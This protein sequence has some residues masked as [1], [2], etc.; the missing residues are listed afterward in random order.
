MQYQTDQIDQTTLLHLYKNM[1]KPRL[2]EEK[3]LVLLRQGKI[4]KWFSGIGQEAISVGVTMAMKDE[5][6]IL[7]MHRNLGIFTTRNVPLFRLFCQWQGKMSGFTKGRDRSFHFGTQE[8][9]LI[10]MIS[11]LGPQLGVADG[12]ALASK[13]KN[14]Q[15][16]TAV[17]TGEGGTSEGDF[18]EALNVASVWQLPVLFC[19]ENNGYGLST[20]TLEQY[21]CENLADRGLGY[22]MESHIIDGNNIV[23]VYQK[24]SE[25]TESMRQNPRPI[26]IEFKTFRM[27]GHEEASGTKYVPQ[28][29]M[30]F[31]E[32]KDP[33]NNF[34]SFLI[35][36]GILMETDDDVFRS[37]IKAE[38]DTALDMAFTEDAIVPDMETELRDVY[39]PFEYE[40]V[41]HKEKTEELRFIDAISTG[42][43]QSMEKHTDLVVMGQ[44][45]ADYGG[46]FKITEGFVEAFGKDRVRNTPIC[47]SSIIEVGMGLSIA[48]IK[49]VVEMQFADFVSSGFNPIVNY[50]AKVHYRWNQKAD[51][52]VRMPCGA[53][54]AA[55]PFHSQT[56]EAWF[57]KTPGLKVVY[58]AFP[59]DAKGLLAT[60]INDPN[61]VL[62]FEHKALYRTV[63]QDVPTD[64][65]TLPF[66]KAALLQEGQEI[67]IISYG[68]GVHWAIS[69]LEKHPNIQADLIDL[70]TLQPL[71]SETILTS[72]KKTGKAI[73]LQEDSLFGGIASDLSAMIM[74][75]CF[76]YLDA[77][78]KRVASM[79]TPIPFIGQLE[80]QY[81]PKSR[82]EIE[83]LELLKY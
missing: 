68:A 79:E 14:R 69:V 17:F 83:L 63:R 18:H 16:V 56:N 73:I 31:W 71:D 2:I 49:S 60:A 7:P 53:G 72:V 13:L 77:P 4:S 22:G 66:G 12:I 50:L 19:I 42:L 10:G 28:D 43:K 39:H 65:Y 47:E 51:V 52:V 8:Y 54:V 1:L 64:Y 80:E 35:E 41:D 38:I 15:E 58:P 27:R 70:R 45:I 78:V 81:L 40:H 34:K 33:L 20:P 75:Q 32:Q 21:F 11:H 67:T 82:F 9:K 37:K 59:Y 30:D 6:Y 5:E 23:E 24:I 26:L 46:V 76:E 36:Q 29:L 61:P 57:T 55:G 25:I 74:E 44:D 3:M 62:F 48:N